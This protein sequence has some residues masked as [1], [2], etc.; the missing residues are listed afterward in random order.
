MMYSEESMGS[1][2]HEQGADNYWEPAC[3]LVKLIIVSTDTA[4]CPAFRLSTTAVTPINKHYAKS[5]YACTL[6]LLD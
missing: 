3:I 2:A 1:H 4:N 5:G 6:V